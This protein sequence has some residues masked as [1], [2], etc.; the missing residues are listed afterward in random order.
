[1]YNWA[2]V[3]I[4]GGLGTVVRYAIAEWVKLNFKTQFPLATLLSN[5]LSCLVLALTLLLLN[6]KIAAQPSLRLLLIV[7][8]CGGFSTFSSFS[9]ETVNLL[10][11]G[12]FIYATANVFISVIACISLVYLLLKNQ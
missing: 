6:E 3:F 7:G 5:L 10:K 2:V 8:F 4:G 1:M 9:F 12:N 11:N